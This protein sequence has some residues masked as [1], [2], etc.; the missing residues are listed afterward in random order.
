MLV[1]RG[2]RVSFT[3]A[4]GKPF[5]A[6]DVP[7]LDASPGHTLAIAGASGCGKTTLLYAL[8]GLY[9]QTQGAITWSARDIASLGEAARGAWRR[10]TIGFIFQDFRLVA[11][12]S[13]MENVL[14]PARFERTALSSTLRRRAGDLLQ[15]FGVP[16]DRGM[17]ADLSRGEAQRVALARALLL[18]PPVILADEPTA[19][20]DGAA[21][22]TVIATLIALAKTEGKLVIAVSH[23]AAL[24]ARFD[25][26]LRLDRRLPQ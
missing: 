10:R 2:V 12:L 14:L 16:P 18:D 1:A 7:A 15:R 5:V 13:P 11:E 19:S 9:R 26:E 22:E 20:L 25:R 17:S 6:L 23:D 4:A 8:A 3:D 24:R 21:A